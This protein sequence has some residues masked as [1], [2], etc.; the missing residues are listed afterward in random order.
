MSSIYYPE[1]WMQHPEVLRLQQRVRELEN[2]LN[3]IEM[4]ARPEVD[5]QTSF[6]AKKIKA[7]ATDEANLKAAQDK[8]KEMEQQMEKFNHLSPIRKMCYH[9]NLDKE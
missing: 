2:K 4:F 9:F 7:A 6:L 3:N 8:V 1:S 5:R